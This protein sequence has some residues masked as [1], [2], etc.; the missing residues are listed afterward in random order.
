[1]TDLPEASRGLIV[2]DIGHFTVRSMSILRDPSGEVADR[3]EPS[4]EALS[5]PIPKI[6]EGRAF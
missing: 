6:R 1:M 3:S 4:V 2:G 5:L